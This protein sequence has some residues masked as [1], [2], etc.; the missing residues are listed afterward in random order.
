[1][2]SLLHKCNKP[3]S[4]YNFYVKRYRLLRTIQKRKAWLFLVLTLRAT[5]QDH[6]VRQ[7]HGVPERG[8]CVCCSLERGGEVCA[9][10]GWAC[11][12]E[13]VGVCRNKTGFSAGLGGVP[14]WRPA[15]LRFQLTR[16]G[17]SGLLLNAVEACG[18]SGCEAGIDEAGF[19]AGGGDSGLQRGPDAEGGGRL[20]GVFLA[21]YR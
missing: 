20:D 18:S 17:R 11:R 2:Q 19:S 3:T 6:S 14:W 1:M 21:D 12:G 16:C 8:R 5:H 13:T 9:T 15:V 10:T 7:A 4:G